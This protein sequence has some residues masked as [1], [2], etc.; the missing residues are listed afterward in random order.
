MEL[1]PTGPLY[2]E[3]GNGIQSVMERLSQKTTSRA[4]SAID[5]I[6]LR[7]RFCRF[8]DTHVSPEEINDVLRMASCLP[9]L[10]RL[11]LLR[12]RVPVS[13]ITK[14]L[15]LAASSGI[16]GGLNLLEELELRSI[17]LAGSRSEMRDMAVALE[18]HAT[19]SKITLADCRPEAGGATRSNHLDAV[20]TALGK[21]VSLS[22]VEL[23]MMELSRWLQ[24]TVSFQQFLLGGHLKRLSLSYMR[25]PEDYIL[26]MADAFANPNGCSVEEVCFDRCDSLSQQSALVMAQMLRRNTSLTKLK[27]VVKDYDD[28]IPIAQALQRNTSS[29]LKHLFLRTYDHQRNGVSP[30]VY[31]AFKTMLEHN[32]TLEYLEMFQGHPMRPILSL[33]PTLNFYLK[34]NRAGRHRLMSCARNNHRGEASNQEWVQT[35]IAARL[36]LQ[37]SYYFLSQNPSVCQVK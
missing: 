5:S 34:V 6:V 28:A 23:D 30:T 21:M 24:S 7:G 10:K 32:Y 1:C 4:T 15:H 9:N 16:G 3:V 31:Q 13:A 20:I 37:C 14:L 18:Q 25:I 11:C 27:L 35:I 36:D 29:G 22:D 2:L 26:A 12:M 8:I 33:D 17:V 19:L